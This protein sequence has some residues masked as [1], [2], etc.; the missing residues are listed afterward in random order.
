MIYKYKKSIM[1]HRWRYGR[2]SDK[3]LQIIFGYKYHMRPFNLQLLYLKNLVGVEIGTREGFNA[4]VMLDTL[5]IK[6]LYLIDPYF[7]YDD[8]KEKYDNLENSINVAKRR[9]YKYRD[10][11][12]FVKKKSEDAKN[13]IPDNLDFVYI[14]GNHSYQYVKKDIELYYP[15][16]KEGGLLAGHDFQA[17]RINDVCLAVTEFSQ[18]HNIKLNGLDRDWWFIK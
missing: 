16:V 2:I 3:F 17:S 12:I 11:I 4:R 18:K 15:K 7:Y 13:D 14:D 1:K 5:D 6:K 8:L 9:L 10:K